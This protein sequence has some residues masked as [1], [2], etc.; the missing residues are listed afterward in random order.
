VGRGFFSGVVVVVVV[1]AGAGSGSGVGARGALFAIGVF[2]L[3]VGF[4]EEDLRGGLTL[5]ALVMGVGLG[6]GV[7]DV[8][9]LDVTDKELGG[10]FTVLEGEEDWIFE[11]EGVAAGVGLEADVAGL[12]PEDE[13][14][15]CRCSC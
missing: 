2:D 7:A 9:S 6:V 1:V 5:A 13:G 8:A 10:G 11:G 15:C 14:N 3:A 12:I 4:E